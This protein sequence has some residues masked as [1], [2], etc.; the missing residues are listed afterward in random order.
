[1]RACSEAQK[2]VDYIQGVTSIEEKEAA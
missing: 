2:A 1:M